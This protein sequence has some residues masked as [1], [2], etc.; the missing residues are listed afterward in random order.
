[1]PLT[2]ADVRKLEKDQLT[3]GFMDIFQMEN[4]L[5]GFVPVQKIDQMRARAIRMVSLPTPGVRRLGSSFSESKGSVDFAEETVYAVGGY[6]DVD[7]LLEED[8]SVIKSPRAVQ[9]ELWAK[10]MAY[11]FNDILLNGTEASERPDGLLQRISSLASGQTIDGAS[12]DLSTGGNRDTN[13]L[14]LIDFLDQLIDAVDGHKA[15]FLLMN[16][17]TKQALRSVLMRKGLWGANKDQFGR[18]INE[19]RGAKIL[20]TGVKAD[21]S[22]LVLPNTAPISGD[23][24]ATIVAGR[25]GE[26]YLSLLQFK[27][28]KVSDLGRQDGTPN[29]R[30]E[31]EWV[32]GLMMPHPR[33]LARIKDLKV[34]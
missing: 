9:T 24:N 16:I 2:L 33:G 32:Y 6:I 3:R 14:A 31:V 11:D 8:K 28:L 5:S 25:F 27:P 34:V 19:Y 4:E 18:E 13:G 22:T 7:Y 15:D 29:L 23:T 1:M 26:D 21:Q 12:L 20:D 30:T 10:A 17:K